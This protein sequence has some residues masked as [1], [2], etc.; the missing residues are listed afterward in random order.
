MK[1][2]KQDNLDKF[3][4]FILTKN[5][6]KYLTLIV[7]IGAFLRYL[8][9]KNVSFLGD[10]MVHGPHAINMWNSGLISTILE[11]PTWF[12]LTDIAHKIFGVTIFSTRFLSF[13]Y[14]TLTIVLIYLLARTIF[15]KRVAIISSILLAISTYHIRYTLMEMD[16]A[17]IFFVLLAVYTFIKYF[18]ENNQKYLYLTAILL[19]TGTLIKTITAFFIPVFVVF[20]FILTKNKSLK[21]NIKSM[22]IVGLI[23]LT[24]ASP[25]I[26]HNVLLYQ[27]KGVVDTYFAQYFDINRE[28]HSGQLGYDNAFNIPQVITGTGDMIKNS[29]FQLDPL[30]FI[31]GIAGMLYALKQR[32]GK[33]SGFLISLFVFGFLILAGSNL[34]PT[35]YVSFIPFLC[36]FAALLLVEIS[37]KLKNYKK[38]FIII[39][40]IILTIANIFLIPQNLLPHLT[41]QTANAPMREFAIENIEENSLVVVDSRIYR[42]R[43]AW[44]FNDKHY[45]ESGYFLQLLAETEKLPKEQLVPITT[46]LVECAKDDCGWGTIKEGE[47]NTSS[48]QLVSQFKQISSQ[49]AEFQSGGGYD[50]ATGTTHFKVYKAEI[51]LHPAS[52][53]FADETHMWFYYPTRYE[54]KEKGWDYLSPKGA[55]A[56]TAH[57]F[58]FLI[59]MLSVLFAILAPFLLFYELKNTKKHIIKK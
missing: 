36:I 12:Y 33:E 10:E 26:I 28:V 39:S 4:D 43:V 31:L 50:E 19:G 51:N 56:K 59:I 5:H 24:F 47:L 23:L 44:L 45:L 41:S 35:H 9:V 40:I 53:T 38:E 11:S 52:L 18:R 34:L 29:F 15:N 55:L 48:E 22:L 16:E 30:I 32:K 8:I 3:L 27:E 1:T 58:G 7:T 20:F 42:G 37:N 14:G 46:Y 13:F 49:V 2:K 6:A 17:L 21:K 25:I 57:K 54:P